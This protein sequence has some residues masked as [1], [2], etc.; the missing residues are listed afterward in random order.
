MK[1]DK[2]SIIINKNVSIHAATLEDFVA[3]LADVKAGKI[4]IS[5]SSPVPR[6]FVV[7]Y[8]VD[9]RY[10]DVYYEEVEMSLAMD[11]PLSIVEEAY[12]TQHPTFKVLNV[13]E[14]TLNEHLCPGCGCKIVDSPDEDVL[15][16]DC[17]E[18]FGH[19]FYSEL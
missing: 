15:C 19:S 3:F 1:P 14:L 16:Q 9:I 4:A 5:T 8:K 2:V 12:R 17:R 10:T 11:A 7:Q 13:R 18:D 6:K